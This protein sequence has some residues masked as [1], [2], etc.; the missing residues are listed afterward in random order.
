VLISEIGVDMSAFPTPK[1]F[2]SWAKMCP[3]ND[4][5][6]GKRRS[7]NTGKGNKR[8]RATL[9]EAT[10]AATR[11]KNSYLVAQYRRLRGR[12]GHS[13]AVIAAGHSILTAAGHMLQNGEL[14]RDLGSDYFTQRNPDHVTN[15]LV[16]HS[17]RS[18]T[19]SRSNLEKSPRDE[20]SLQTYRQPALPKQ[21][22]RNDRRLRRRMRHRPRTPPHGP[23]PHRRD[24][25]STPGTRQ[26]R[27]AS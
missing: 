25:L 18:D 21:Y 12:R 8:L 7:G 10:L 20:I 6:G 5:S 14:Y 4:Q 13:K 9:T 17:K 23:S 2:A 15:R 1:Y 3:G 11:A 19:T 16:R 26:T 27:Q 22:R 24:A